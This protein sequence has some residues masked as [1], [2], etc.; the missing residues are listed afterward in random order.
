MSQSIFRVDSVASSRRSSCCFPA[1]EKSLSTP[2][3][4]E[5]KNFLPLRYRKFRPFFSPFKPVLKYLGIK[6][7]KLSPLN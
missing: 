3:G 4:G 1:W 2:D 7:K 6:S 5:D